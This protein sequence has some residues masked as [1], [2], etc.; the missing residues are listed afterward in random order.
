LKVLAVQGG[1]LPGI[2]TRDRPVN[3]LA[4]I[5]GLDCGRPPNC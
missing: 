2:V 1:T 4:D 3:S 5:K